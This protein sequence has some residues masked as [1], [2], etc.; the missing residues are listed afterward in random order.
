MARRNRQVEIVTG[1]D[2]GSTGIRIAVGQVVPDE[3]LGADV[4]IIGTAQVA[5]LGIEKGTITSI[6]EAVSSISHVLEEVERLVGVPIEHVWVGVSSNHIIA[7]ESR[8][9]VAVAKTDGEISYEDVDR[10]IEAAQTVAAPLNYEVL[11][12][13]PRGYVVDGQTGIKDPSGMTGVRLEVDAQMIYGSTPHVKNITKAIYRTGVDIDDLVLSLIATGDT[14]LTDRQKQLGVGLV[15]IGG[16]TTTLAVYEEGNII[17]TAVI[18]IGSNHV[19][20]DLALGLQT[21]IDVAEKIKLLYGGCLVKGMTAKDCIDL[22]EFGLASQAVPKKFV[23]EIIAARVVEILEKINDELRSIDRLG[24]LP[25]GIVFT[26]G[27][28]KLQD[29]VEV[30]KQVTHMNAAH[31]LPMGIRSAT[32]S[33]ND[34]AFAAAISL[35]AWGSSMNL[36]TRGTKSKVRVPG[37]KQAVDKVRQLFKFLVP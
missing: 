19:T 5:S 18:P 37:G 8:G 1:L 24:L 25:A 3:R 15:D 26:G 31:G 17:H 20:N 36:R 10:V 21:D 9:V 29:L 6:E 14:V 34:L 2:I 12:V 27:G 13:L 11:H 4:Q 16:S 35:V 28:A 32:E 30:A 7:N 33:I 22:A 23:R